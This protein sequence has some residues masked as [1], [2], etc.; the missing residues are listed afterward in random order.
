M[1]AVYQEKAP[2]APR[3]YQ[4]SYRDFKGVDLTSAITEIDDSRS[5][6]APNMIAD[7]SGFPCKR[8][9]YEVIKALTGRINGIFPFLTLDG[10]EKLIVH[11]GTSIH[12]Y[13]YN[14]TVEEEIYTSANDARS[15]SFVYGGK[16]YILDGENYISWDGS[17]EAASNVTNDAFVPTTAISMPPTGGGT[18]LEPINLLSNKRIN[19]FLGTEG[20]VQYQLDAEGIDGIVKVETM[21]GSGGWMETTSYTV[22]TQTGTV[23]FGFAP[24]VSP[25][26]GEDNI[27]ITFQKTVAGN[28]DKILK[29]RIN[30]FYGIGNDS[31]VFVSGNPGARNYD[32]YSWSGRAD[33]FPDINYNIVGSEAGAVMGYCKQYDDLIII[34]EPTG[35]DASIFSRSASLND[36][37]KALFVTR[38]GISGP[39]AVSM[40]CFGTLADD[41]VFLSREGIYGL[42]TSSITQQ[43]TTQ[44]RSHYVNEALTKEPGLDEA[45]CCVNAG[46]LYVFINNHVYIADS[47]QR[48]T[49]PAK[50]YGYE[51]FYWDNVPARSVFAWR[52]KIW[53]GTENGNL[54][55]FKTELEDGMEAYN[56]N[57]NPISAAWATKMDR[58]TDSAVFKKITKTGT[59]VLVKPFAKSDGTIAFV[60]DNEQDVKDYSM[61]TVFDFDNVDFDNFN[62]GM[63]DNPF[64]VPARKKKRK[65]KMWQMIVKND[66][67]NSAF[68]LYEIR[69][70]YILGGFIKR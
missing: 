61:S 36:E 13:S 25:I 53:F 59:G 20:A 23:T 33:Y 28:A 18:D 55:R 30:A 21:N 38:Q 8:A 48:N 46:Y 39:G 14:L 37:N 50:S 70:N 63:L 34:K 42:D 66:V 51:W 10:D 19:S 64:F 1:M 11:S 35:Q 62:F 60:T 44:M 6:Y 12:A 32:W 26:A 22:N 58:L 24:G 27:R 31:R 16:I 69:V 45:V 65:A 47:K 54:C 3:V 56:D 9:G 4:K 57:G 52:G 67:L 17:A 41:N 68:G 43:K 15:T 7:E 5:P 40:Y 49:N 2:P 29:C